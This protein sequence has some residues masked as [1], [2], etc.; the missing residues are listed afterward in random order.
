MVILPGEV[1]NLSEASM[2]VDG[3][4]RLV[5]RGRKEVSLIGFTMG[6]LSH[7]TMGSIEIAGWYWK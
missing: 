1:I 5:E 2:S 6:V 4:Q 3:K 7:S